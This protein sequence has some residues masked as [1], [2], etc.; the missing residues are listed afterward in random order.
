GELLTVNSEAQLIAP[1][2]APGIELAHNILPASCSFFAIDSQG[3]RQE[4]DVSHDLDEVPLKLVSSSIHDN[5]MVEAL[6][7]QASGSGALDSPY[8]SV[9]RADN[10]LFCGPFLF[11]TSVTQSADKISCVLDLACCQIVKDG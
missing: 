4:F 7:R 1:G 9:A 8:Q 3:R 10:F 11:D 2:A 6:N 5:L